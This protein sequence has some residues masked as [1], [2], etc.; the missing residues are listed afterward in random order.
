MEYNFKNKWYLTTEIDWWNECRKEL[1]EII[2]CYNNWQKEDNFSEEKS[3][4]LL[5]KIE[6]GK[7]T[8]GSRDG[9]SEYWNDLDEMEKFVK[10]SIKVIS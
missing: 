4:L 6:Y 9:G 7:Q 8:I 10:A 5:A 1:N 2:D 3:V